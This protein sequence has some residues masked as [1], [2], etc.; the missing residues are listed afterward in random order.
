MSMTDGGW[1]RHMEYINTEIERAMRV[2][3]GYWR[4]GQNMP[5][6]TEKACNEFIDDLRRLSYFDRYE[7]EILRALNRACLKDA[8]GL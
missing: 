6:L 1:C 7:I 5:Y 2:I 3:L 8:R 4:T